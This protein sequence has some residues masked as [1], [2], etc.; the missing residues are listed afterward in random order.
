MENN[1]LSI[2]S[3]V[4]SLDF[5]ATA[6]G[7]DC[8]AVIS[9]YARSLQS[10]K[11][12]SA[13]L[14]L[15]SQD[16]F[17][18]DGKGDSYRI[19]HFGCGFHTYIQPMENGKDKFYHAIS[20]NRA[21]SSDDG[22]V[23]LFEKGNEG[24][25]W[26]DYLM[27]RY[28]L[29][30]LE[31]WGGVLYGWAVGDGHLAVRSAVFSSSD[32]PAG[33]FRWEDRAV[34]VSG[35]L[36]GKVSLTEEALREGVSGLLRAGQI[37]ISRNPQ[38]SLDFKDM[39]SYFKK[40]GP[41]LV[42]NLSGILEPL[43][44]LDGEAHD[45]T[46][47]SMR[48]YPQQL[49]QINGDVRLVENGKYAILNHGMGTGKTV[50]SMSVAE[51]YS[52][53]KYLRSHPGKGLADAYERPGVINYRNV[54][55]CPG[56]LVGK[57][58]KELSEQI[59]YAKVSILNDFRQ[60]LEL[61]RKGAARDGKEWYV[62]SKDFSKLSYQKEPTPKRRRY[63]RIM[64][65]ECCDCG[66]SV[67]APGGICM[68]CGSASLKLV[69]SGQMGYGMACPHCSQ[70]LVE[71]KHQPNL[72]EYAQNPVAVLD[73]DGFLSQRDGNSICYYCG[74][75][76][77]QPHVAN[78]GNMREPAWVR[79]THYSNKAHKGKKTVWVHKKYMWDY[80]H[81]IEEEPLNIKEGGQGVR[82]YSPAE[83]MKRYM[84]GFFDFA[85]F[86]EAHLYKGG[87]TGQGHAMHALMKCSKKWLALTGTIA[88]GYAN[89]LFYL[90]WRLEPQRMVKKGYKFSDEMKFSENYGRVERQYEYG[91]CQADGEYNASCKGRQINSP[92]VKPGIS[93]L[94]FVDFL[95]DRTTFLDL[96]DMSKYLPPLKEKVVTVY[97]E[98]NSVEDLEITHSK[99]IIRTLGMASKKK[100]S[101]GMGILSSMLQFSL[102]YNDKPFG[103]DEIKNPRDGSILARPNNYSSFMDTSEFGRLLSKEKK[104]VELVESEIS[105]GRNCF[106]YAEYTG[107]PQTCVS[108]RL[109]EIIENYC[110]LRGKVEVLESASPKASERERWMHRRAEDG[111]RVFISNPRC[112]ETGLDFCFHENGVDYNYP[113]IIF[114]QMGYSL[115]T[116][117]QASRRHYRLN[118]R[119]EC[120]TYYLALGSTVQTEVI[121]LIAEKQS[122]TAAI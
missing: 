60:L 32:T 15:S 8:P 118:Q 3:S 47:N 58:A 90:L 92:K 50:V 1:R 30:L 53:R 107:M 73:H 95:L 28:N 86:D 121:R 12:F 120:R 56:H 59:P 89:H 22:E 111:V 37:F 62:V 66:K 97:P 13:Y 122:A 88:G 119:K 34:P 6:D 46:L 81:G 5:L 26:Y 84:R 21:L 41:S 38:E 31:E 52:V 96:T 61:R 105:E 75:S 40:Y 98:R 55:M 68:S 36:A 76:L 114:Y 25:Q 85:I 100:E 69:P 65:K 74:N 102:S 24:K 51:S 57:W 78:I 115:F 116:I 117:W 83:F 7:Y 99:C 72:E 18:R 27:H 9:Y 14:N 45:F 17:L 110:N 103:V 113:T 44:P 19:S 79:A 42:S 112:V 2:E 49:A 23:I 4:V 91:G 94:I 64:R 10:V 80:F 63:G 11:S 71:N 101:G 35:L 104:L 108:H 48:L 39:D 87:G 67:L 29:P 33:S 109:K 16:I 43:S 54:V 93:P 20:L 70:I 82:K 77:W 106:I